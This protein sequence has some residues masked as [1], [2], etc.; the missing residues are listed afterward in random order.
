M[1]ILLY[2]ITIITEIINASILADEFIRQYF[3]MRERDFYRLLYIIIKY[4]RSTSVSVQ[5]M[6]FDALLTHM[7]RVIDSDISTIWSWAE[8]GQK[9]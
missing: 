4:S 2:C 5:N 3:Y 8:L 7:I 6:Y 9:I 1:I